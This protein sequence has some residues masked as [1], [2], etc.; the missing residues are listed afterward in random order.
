MTQSEKMFKSIQSVE[1]ALEIIDDRFS[2]SRSDVIDKPIFILASSWRSGSTLLQRLINSNEQT[3]IWGEPFAN[4]HLIQ[5]QADSLRSLTET[6]PQD[7]WFLS[8]RK[9]YEKKL[10]QQVTD[11]LY[12]DVSDLVEGYR[13]LIRT[14]YK[15]PAINN[16]YKRWG[17]KEVR[18]T[19]KHGIYLQWLFP[20]AQFLLLHRNPYEAYKSIHHHLGKW[21]LFSKWPT[22]QIS[23]VFDFAHHWHLLVQ[24]YL[25]DA[26]KLG[27]MVI[28]YERLYQ[29]NQVIA[30][31]SHYLNLELNQNVVKQKI[32]SSYNKHQVP[33]SEIKKL[34]KIV[35]PLAENLGYYPF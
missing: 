32:G 31:I 13:N 6:Y 7:K 30:D 24:G 10:D 5:N 27:A 21:N 18:L 14:V 33:K 19:S 12:P 23:N 35:G 34:Q 1:Q 15:T 4:C 3:L 22:D 11:N 29:D 25:E 20:N 8:S 17:L 16:G 26:Q 9:N 28:P 2:L